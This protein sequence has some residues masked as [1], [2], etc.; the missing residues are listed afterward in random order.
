MAN[1]SIVVGPNGPVYVNENNAGKQYVV[2][3]VYENE[4][5]ASVT[6]LAAWA[7]NSNLPVLGTG[8]Y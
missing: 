5:A 6:F 8:T 4:P 1:Q 2:A 7:Q 3:G